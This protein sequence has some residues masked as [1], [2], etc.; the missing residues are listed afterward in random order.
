MYS[1]VINSNFRTNMPPA[2]LG[3]ILLRYSVTSHKG[4][5][6]EGRPRY[7][8]WS[9][10]NPLIPVPVDGKSKGDLP[11]TLS[12]C[13]LDKPNVFLLALKKAEIGEGIIIR[14]NE[15]EGRTLKSM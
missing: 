4:D 12:F 3:D 14:L 6:I 8:G 5:W 9:A 15:T 7:L 13:Q 1:F 11:E 10:G 2:Q